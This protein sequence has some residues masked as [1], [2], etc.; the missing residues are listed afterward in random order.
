MWAFGIVNNKGDVLIYRSFKE[1]VSRAEFGYFG[2]KVIEAKRSEDSP[3]VYLHP[4]HFLHVAYADVTLVVATRENSNAAMIFKFL[5]RFVELLRAYFRGKLNENEV[6]KGFELIYELLD[7]CIDYGYPQL[8]EVDLLKKYVSKG[9]F[10]EIQDSETLKKITIAAT[11]ATSW[12]PEG[13]RHKSNEIFIDVVESV[14]GL[15]S[16]GGVLLKADVL[17]AVK[18]RCALSGMPE[19]KFGINDKLA[20]TQAGSNSTIALDDIRFHQCVRLAR[21]EAERAVTFV[22]PDGSFDLMSY[23][24]TSNVIVPFK[25][26]PLLQ[27]RGDRI[28]VS[29]S[30]RALFDEALFATDLVLVIPVPKSVGGVS[31]VNAGGGRAKLETSGSTGGLLGGMVG[32]LVGDKSELTPE[33]SGQALVWR[34]PRMGGGVEETLRA[35][36]LVVSSQQTNWAPISLNFQVP[37]FTASGLRVRFLR[38]QEKSNYKATKWIRYLTQAS[39]FQHRL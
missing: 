8:M 6:R 27:E 39:S 12:R 3:V 1:G 30:L 34:I 5:T 18:I 24:V 15:I 23:R 21:F 7:E 31:S 10:Q 37:M 2:T 11:G 38:V 35:E 4:T 20:T 14:N 16:S 25:I 17:G 29:I 9:G 19:C 13:I 22:P 28:D 26:T 32:A 33:F 36:L